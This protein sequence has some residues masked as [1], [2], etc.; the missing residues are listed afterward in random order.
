[1]GGT[2]QEGCMHMRSDPTE[3]QYIHCLQRGGGAAL[4]RT[5]LLG[6]P[7]PKGRGGARAIRP[8]QAKQQKRREDYLTF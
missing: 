6:S 8:E 4:I 7:L 1:M 2:V 5:Q 3:S